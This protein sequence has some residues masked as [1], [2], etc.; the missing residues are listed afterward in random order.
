MT[1]PAK[2]TL[3]GHVPKPGSA[4]GLPSYLSRALFPRPELG[5]WHLKGRA[6]DCS[7][8]I[9]GKTRRCGSVCILVV[10]VLVFSLLFLCRIWCVFCVIRVSFCVFFVGVLLFLSFFSCFF[11]CFLR[12][13]SW[14]VRSL[15]VFFVRGFRL[16]GPLA[17]IGP[18]TVRHSCSRNSPVCGLY[19]SSRSWCLLLPVGRDELYFAA[20]VWSCTLFF[21]FFAT[22]AKLELKGQ[23]RWRSQQNFSQYNKN[24]STALNPK[25]NSGGGKKKII[26]P[27]WPS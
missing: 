13:C 20:A 25:K 11:C 19:E 7:R 6:V 3:W 23:K 18:T 24:Q 9:L 1:P 15:L 27:E 21:F 22:K 5:G 16:C 4:P 10:C 14:S 8:R 2:V 17:L 26:D 12:F